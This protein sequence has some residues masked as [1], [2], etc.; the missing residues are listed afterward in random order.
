MKFTF[1]CILFFLVLF[2]YA[3]SYEEY[4]NQA[5]KA[6]DDKNPKQAYYIFETAFKDKAKIGKYDLVNAAMVAAKVNQNKIA[7]DWLTKSISKGLGS[8][9]EELDYVLNDSSYSEL[10]NDRKWKKIIKGVTKN[11]LKEKHNKQKDSTKW[12]QSISKRGKTINRKSALRPGFALHFKN[13]NG[14]ELPYLVYVPKNIKKNNKNKTVVFLHGG[15]V[16]QGEFNYKDPRTKEEPIFKIADSLNCIV[17]YPFGKKSF[18]WVNQPKAFQNILEII[19]ETL[20]I[21][22]I[23]RNEIFLGGMSNGGSAVFWFASQ[24]PNMFNGFFAISGLPQLSFEPIQ[25]NNISQGKPFY[26]IN[27]KN[28]QIYDINEI[29][30]I[31]D[32]QKDLATDWKFKTIESSGHGFIYEPEKGVEILI[33]LLKDLLNDK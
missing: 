18:G 20:A 19:Q 23:D 24:K 32:L 17:I 21:Y 5:S 8:T 4:M 30:H 28:D 7:I 12:I 22:P 15:V 14:I 26:S 6:I 2:S 29:Q 13:Y 16:N 31:Y 9:K 25:F 33:S 3:Q 1:T 10:H 27:D 11:F